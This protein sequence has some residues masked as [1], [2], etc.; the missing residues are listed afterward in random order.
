MNIFI[1]GASGFIGNVF[2]N[3][4]L[5]RIRPED[6]VYILVR[7]ILKLSDQR[8]IQLAGSLET[9][10]KYENEI[11]SSDYFFHI[12]AESRMEGGTDYSKS[13]TVPTLEIVNILKKGKSLKKLIYIS[14]IAAV[15]RTGND[16]C[17]L[18]LSADS[19][20]FPT[21]DYGRAKLTAEKHVIESGLPYA[22]IR[23]AFVYGKY[24]RAES[25]VNAFVSMV[26]RRSPFVH[27]NFSGKVSLIHVD[28]LASALLNCIYGDA[29][30]GRIYFGETETSTVGDIFKVIYAKVHNRRLWQIALPRIG[31][32]MGRIHALLPA[33]I[34]I[35]FF[36][37]FWARDDRFSD[38]LLKGIELK[39]IKNSI[40]DVISTNKDTLRNAKAHGT[41]Q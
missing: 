19:R 22:I 12:A 4:L 3:R 18:P 21:T 36:N 35:L 7:S 23:P 16:N 31:G 14:S 34:A 27:F 5:R 2:L 9:L 13:I 11:L 1:T 10:G 17:V 8:V 41:V 33:R 32:L 28:D 30:A 39:S 6:K 24:M 40:I 15:G 38:E 26:C 29:P 37:Y 20:P 25:H